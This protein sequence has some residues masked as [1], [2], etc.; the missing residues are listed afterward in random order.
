MPINLQQADGSLGA[1]PMATGAST[2]NLD[3][4]FV[5]PS[6]FVGSIATNL[7]ATT[8]NFQGLFDVAP[9]R[10]G[11][12][13]AT[14]GAATGIS[15]TLQGLATP[16]LSTNANGV[17]DFTQSRPF[18][19]MIKTGRPWRTDTGDG[20]DNL[21][22]GGHL[23]A[24]G[25]VQ[26]LPAGAGSVETTWDWS[27]LEGTYQGGFQ[28]VMTWDGTGSITA[29]GVT[30]NSTLSNSQTFTL[31]ADPGL[32]GVT[33]TDPG[34]A[35][36]HIRNIRIIP[37]QW[38]SLYDAGERINP[39]Y[40]LFNQDMRLIR[41]MDWMQTNWSEVVDFSDYTTINAVTYS[42]DPAGGN[43]NN[44]NRVPLEMIAEM[45][46]KTQADCWVNFPHQATDACVTAIAQFFFDNLESNLVCHFE[47]T[48]ELWNF[49]FPHW[50]YA[51]AQAEAEWGTPPNSIN[52]A[53]N[54]QGKRAYECSVLVDAVY[55]GFE[56]R[57]KNVMGCNND[58]VTFGNE[59]SLTAPV[60]QA[61]DP[62]NYVRPSSNMQAMAI[63]P[64]YGA[65]MMNE[66]INPGN[67]AALDSAYLA[68]THRAWIYNYLTDATNDDSVPG[69]LSN[70]QLQRGLA[71]TE[72]IEILQYEG[73]RHYLHGGDVSG[74]ALLAMLDF[75]RNS[76]EDANLITQSWE[77]WENLPGDGP[78]QVFADIG[79]YS[80][81]GAWNLIEYYGTTS[82][83]GRALVS[84]SE[85][86]PNWWGDLTNHQNA[87]IVGA[88]DYTLQAASTRP[89]PGVIQSDFHMWGHSGFTYQGGD[90][91][92][93]SDFTQAG[94]WIG[95]LADHAG[96]EFTGGYTF[97]QYATHLTA[98]W[99]NPS[100][101]G[102]YNV[103]NTSPLNGD[104][105]SQGYEHVS[106][107]PANFGLDGHGAP[108]FNNT[109]AGILAD[110]QALHDNIIAVD[111]TADHIIT[112]YWPDTGFYG[113]WSDPGAVTRAQF[114]TYNN[115][116]MGGLLDWYILLQDDMSSSGRPVRLIPFPAII[117]WIFENE[118]YI[119]GP[120]FGA[121]FG[122]SAPHGSENIYCLIGL[123]FFRALYGST[124]DLTGFS[125]PV[126]ATQMRTEVTNNFDAIDAAVQARLN[127]HQANGVNVFTAA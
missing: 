75:A 72:G 12:I 21:I 47:Y 41:F 79:G 58:D 56:S 100:I 94:N 17:S 6:N 87:A 80:A 13:S 62:G 71:T 8:S 18:I 111:P 52:D 39:D 97:G 126:G 20:V 51:S 81:F 106:S 122:D 44:E 64:Y 69:M 102:A 103:G 110:V 73:A 10:T 25:W 55:A 16:T 28:C 109:T 26:S 43:E 22:A 42:N 93:F 46:N 4:T 118:S 60:W 23:D 108:P 66:T 34:T 2:A 38:Q 95:L 90:A 7:T 40:L 119:S 19:D 107:M 49:G 83:Y 120:S 124:P 59:Q 37:V 33:I 35:P 15:S 50:Q 82:P 61:N 105:A 117:G 48:N 112:G 70:M 89:R 57:R 67:R 32:W 54:W 125:F 96:M 29:F 45:A 116:A 24:D 84:L 86:V 30:I 101:G 123:V 115:D 91:A 68:G 78:F 63:A 65:F 98:G 92:P 1:A 114:T 27:S 9:D 104:Y 76:T 99:P 74:N 113:D 36:N 88:T 127:F 53:L 31:N 11:T 3:G 121:W 5:N 77:A 85:N 14:L